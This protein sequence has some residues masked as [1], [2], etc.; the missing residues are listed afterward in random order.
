[1]AV[2]SYT[3]FKKDCYNE[4]GIL[5]RKKSPGRPRAVP[6][7]IVN[8]LTKELTSPEGFFSYGE[9]QQWL[10]VFYDLKVK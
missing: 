8:Q 10:E 7:E 1:M 5:N 6:P 4:K 3:N 9:V 2:G